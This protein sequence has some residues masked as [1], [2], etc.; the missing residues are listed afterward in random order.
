MYEAAKLTGLNVEFSSHDDPDDDM[1]RYAK[2]CHFMSAT[3]TQQEADVL[4]TEFNRVSFGDLVGDLHLQLATCP[5]Q[6]TLAESLEE[7]WRAEGFGSAVDAYN[8]LG[9]DPMAVND[10]GQGT[11]ELGGKHWWSAW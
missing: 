3:R 4:G 2:A 10:G 8:Q 7:S 9:G 5:P 1:C 6:R 11:G